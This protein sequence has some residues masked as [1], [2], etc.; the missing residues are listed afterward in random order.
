MGILV[1]ITL[2]VALFNNLLLLPALILLFE[3]GLNKSNKKMRARQEVRSSRP[4]TGLIS[5]NDKDSLKHH[6]KEE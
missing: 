2:L 4:F 1:S 6:E 3:K 5:E